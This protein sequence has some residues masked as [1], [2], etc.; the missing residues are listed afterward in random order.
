MTCK[1][2]FIGAHGVGK[3]IL[4]FSLV[5]RLRAMQVDADVAF[6]N[7]RRSPFPINEAT[8]VQGQMWILAAQWREELEAS[9]RCSFIVCD[10]SMLDNYAYLVRA[11]GP[12]DYLEAFL[13]HWMRTYDLLVHVPI[14]EDTI[15]PDTVRSTSTAF[16]REIDRIVR[17]L[18]ARFR[19]ESRTLFLADDRS[20]HLDAVLGALRERGLLG[21]EPFQGRL[22]SP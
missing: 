9:L 11:A 5:S 4:T 16:Q 13:R 14:L 15:T 6:E 1:I 20:V 8:T 2:A 3:T 21:T 17:D 22:F 19:I 12:Q 18:L 10:R 7:S